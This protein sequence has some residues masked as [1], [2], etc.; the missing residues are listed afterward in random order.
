VALISKATLNKGRIC[1]LNWII[2][3]LIFARRAG[4]FNC[5]SN[6]TKDLVAIQYRKNTKKKKHSN[7]I[8]GL[9]ASELQGHGASA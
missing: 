2:F 5:F 9:L 3:Y 4:A 6:Q 8:Y 7:R 1:F